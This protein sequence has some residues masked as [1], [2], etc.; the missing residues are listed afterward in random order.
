[1]PTT[2]A[3]WEYLWK[4]T[5]WFVGN[6]LFG[7]APIVF[8][9]CI[10]VIS[11]FKFGNIQIDS[12][13]HEG[14]ILFVLCAI[15]GSIALDYALGGYSFKGWE[16]FHIFIVPL[17]ILLLVCLNYLLICLTILDPTRFD[18]ASYTSWICYAI[19][20]GYIMLQ[21]TNLLIKED[22]VR[23]LKAKL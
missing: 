19:S 13:V 21:K 5:K 20:M 7:I 6:F 17:G 1:M 3:Y 15:M 23:D 22:A 11:E 18:I 16:I 10:Y 12:L 4:T 8:M 9:T 2:P 14:V